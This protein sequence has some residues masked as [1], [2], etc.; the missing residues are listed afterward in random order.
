VSP[1]GVAVLDK[2]AGLTS[3]DVVARVRR[4]LGTRRVGHAGTLD[5]LATGVLVV[6]VGEATKLAPFLTAADKRYA[7]DVVLGSATDTLDAGGEVVARE[8]LPAWWSDAAEAAARVEAALAQERARRLQEPPQF[9]AIKIGGRAAH[10]RARAGEAVEL[11]ARP[12]EVVELRADGLAPEGRIALSMRVSKGYYV[13]SLA[14]DLGE[15]L[16]VP[17]HLGGLRRLASGPFGLDDAVPLDA[18]LATRLVS[19]VESARRALPTAT[20]TPAGATRARAGAALSAGDF[21][22]PPP[23]AASAW[24]D[25]GGEL[26][27]IGE[28]GP[29]GPRVLRGFAPGSS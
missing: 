26:V 27:A 9:S 14:R 17:A 10:R 23:A 6:M 2:P 29:T 5:P 19:L 13:R 7:A 11:A 1:A 28:V 16:G 4:L 25:E 15:A 3:H 12:V 21:Q 20:L 18:S 24:L 22:A 8:A